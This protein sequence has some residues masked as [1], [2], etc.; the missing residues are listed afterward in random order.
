M[1][2]LRALLTKVEPLERHEREDLREWWRALAED[3][4]TFGA[5][6]EDRQVM[7]SIKRR[8]AE[9]ETKGTER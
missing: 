4:R 8:L 5:T 9:P 2:H 3:V 7:A 1:S 6:P